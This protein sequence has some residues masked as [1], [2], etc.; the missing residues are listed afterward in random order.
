MMISVKLLKEFIATNKQLNG[1][2]GIPTDILQLF[3]DFINANS[4]DIDYSDKIKG[5]C[6]DCKHTEYCEWLASDG[7]GYCSEFEPKADVKT[8]DKN[9]K[10][11]GQIKDERCRGR[12]TNVCENW[13]PIVDKVESKEWT[14]SGLPKDIKDRQTEFLNS[15]R[16][17]V[18]KS[19]ENCGNNNSG[20]CPI[21]H[22]CG[23]IKDE[24]D[25]WTPIVDKVEGEK[26][27]E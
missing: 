3:L 5:R 24:P 19:C 25:K 12:W 17:K 27:N 23:T 21:A 26:T 4:I 1:Y 16:P 10:N 2:T 7:Y 18:E 22:T 11:C 15:C 9:C 6:K 14:S 20:Y 13:T 8:T